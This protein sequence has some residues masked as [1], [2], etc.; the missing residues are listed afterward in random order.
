MTVDFLQVR[1]PPCFSLWWMR[2]YRFDPSHPLFLVLSPGGPV[3]QVGVTITMNEELLNGTNRVVFDGVT[4]EK[5]C[6]RIL[7]LA[8]VS[9]DCERAR[10][11]V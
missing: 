4:T 3:P 6:E 8:T 1:P 7:Q 11:S 5:E 2:I 9:S 10:P